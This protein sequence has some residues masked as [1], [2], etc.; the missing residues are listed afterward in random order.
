MS[1]PVKLVDGVFFNCPVVDAISHLSVS[2][3][4][5]LDE[6]VPFLGVFG[7]CMRGTT[8]VLSEVSVLDGQGANAQTS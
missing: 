5:M 1:W 4:P 6:V 7:S 3:G 2:P 8:N